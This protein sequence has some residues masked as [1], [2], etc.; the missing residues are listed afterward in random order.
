MSTASRESTEK[1]LKALASWTP[2]GDEDQLNT[3]ASMAERSLKEVKALTEYEDTKAQRILTAIAFLAALAGGMFAVASRSISDSGV[4]AS[5]VSAFDPKSHKTWLVV[6]VYGGFLFYAFLL[7]VGAALV[8]H[9][10]K[11]KFKIPANWGEEPSSGRPKSFLFFK[12]II[13]VT[14]EQWVQAYVTSDAKALRNEYIKNSVWET[15]LVADK[16]RD[17]L[18]PLEPGVAILL[19]STWILAGW[20]PIAISAIAFLR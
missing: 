9:A 8:I 18:R 17:K 11:P 3:L 7:A 10:V 6:G 16:I 19:W 4:L 5:F 12:Q 1:A 13:A 14:P 20:L 2:S 15:Y